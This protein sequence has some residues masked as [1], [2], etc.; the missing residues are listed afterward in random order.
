[1]NRKWDMYTIMHKNR[2]VAAIRNDGSCTIYAKSFMPYNL[3]L[4]KC[5]V[6]DI[7]TKLNNLENFYFWCASRVL[8]LDRKYAKEILN[9]IG[10]TQSVTDRDRAMI[11]LTY[12]CLTLTDVYWVKKRNEKVTFE[13]VNLYN[14]SLSDAFVDVSL[15]GKSLTVHNQQLLR[16]NDVAGDLSTSGVAPKAW[17]RKED[18]FYLYKDGNIDE[19]E[20]ELM[21]SQIIR[22][23]DVDQIQYEADSYAGEVVSSSSLIT[24]PD[25][26][27]VAA[28]FVEIYAQNHNKSLQDFI[29]K[30]DPYG[31]YMMN[32]LDY[33]IGNNDRHWG[34]WGI[35][36]DNQTNKPIKLY[37]LMDFNRAFHDYDTLD[38]SKC[39]P[40]Y[41]KLSQKEAALEAVKKIGLNQIKEIP[42]PKKMK[43]SIWDMLQKRLAILKAA[44]Q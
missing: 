14:H 37:P 29:L 5:E 31:Y 8:S 42:R 27:I 22:C 17:I 30:L 44:E 40:S 2:K 24:S 32:I 33:L 21:A 18:G 38:G 1:M 6:S 28:E 20:S 34:N 35:L 23:F 9:T 39:L 41:S 7:D 43:D 26:S 19:V 3:Y 13:D 25:R 10:A 36:V 16:D 4:E 12:R 11:S 15:R